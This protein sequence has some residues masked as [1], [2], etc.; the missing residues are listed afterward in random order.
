M[1]PS[2]AFSKRGSVYQGSLLLRVHMGETKCA[3]MEGE[4]ISPASIARRIA[5]IRGSINNGKA[6]EQ[7]KTGDMY[8]SRDSLKVTKPKPRERPEYLSVMTCA[9]QSP[10][11]A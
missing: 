11:W 3:R 5:Q 2:V 8:S 9:S 7:D 1:G 6:R 10:Y 4:M